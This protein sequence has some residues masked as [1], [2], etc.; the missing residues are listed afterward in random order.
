MN[1]GIACGRKIFDAL[2]GFGAAGVGHASEGAPA[3]DMARY[4]RLDLGGH[5]FEDAVDPR[6]LEGGGGVGGEAL[7]QSVFEF[8]AFL[9]VYE[10]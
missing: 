2:N 1:R 8:S 3:F 9:E 4:G 5:G 7:G 6:R 10:Y